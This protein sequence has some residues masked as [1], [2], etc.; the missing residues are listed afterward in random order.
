MKIEK[1]DDEFKKAI[2]SGIDKLNKALD[3]YE[4]GNVIS[5]EEYIKSFKKAYLAFKEDYDK[6]EKLN[7]GEIKNV[8]SYSSGDGR[9]IRIQ[10]DP[11]KNRKVY[12]GDEYA[13]LDIF[14]EDGRIW[15]NLITKCGYAGKVKRFIGENR[16]LREYLDLFYEYRPL[17]ELYMRQN[18]TDPLP[19][20]DKVRIFDAAKCCLT[21]SFSSPDDSL[22]KGLD[23]VE[24]TGTVNQ[25]SSRDSQDFSFKLCVDLR[26]GFKIDHN[27]SEINYIKLDNKRISLNYL[28]E[29]LIS[30]IQINRRHLMGCA[31]IEY[32]EDNRGIALTK[33]DGKL[34]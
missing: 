31:I 9:G 14:E 34:I 4:E 26:N 33:T 18:G 1:R 30:I 17:F 10:L 32:T 7:I 24:I 25:L 23:T 20:C 16:V 28:P 3:D 6:Q 12:F 15:A 13:Y 22:I 5:I 19:V 27:D 21:I 8:V 2:D 29:E 11:S